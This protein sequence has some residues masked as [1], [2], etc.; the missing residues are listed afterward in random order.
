[1]ATSRGALGDPAWATDPALD[2]LAGRLAHAHAIDEHLGAF[3]V[4]YIPHVLMQLLQDA[5]VPAGAVQR[6][7]DHLEDP[8]LAHRRFFRPMVHPE[9]GEVPYEGHQYTIAGYDNGP[10]C[11]HRA[12]ASTP[13][14][15]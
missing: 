2:T 6:S 9:M 1:M 15:C 5:G 4:R 12:W 10:R 7:S 11:R 14:R 8:Q 3:T 13:S